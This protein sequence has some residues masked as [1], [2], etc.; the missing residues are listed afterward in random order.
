MLVRATLILIA[1]FVGGWMVFDGI[2]VL[3]YGRFFG[4][5]K[6]GPWSAVVSSIGLNPLRFGVPFLARYPLASVCRGHAISVVLGVVWGPIRS[7]CNSLVSTDRHI[8][9][10]DLYCFAAHIQ[11]ETASAIRISECSN[12]IDRC[13]HL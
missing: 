1:L 13:C 5:E 2:H 4:P 10:S 12:K 7:D 11:I 9:L 3:I 8:V 6:P